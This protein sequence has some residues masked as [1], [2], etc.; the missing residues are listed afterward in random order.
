MMKGLWWM[1]GC[2]S[3]QHWVPRLRWV[4]FGHF[5]Y[6]LVGAN[7]CLG[8][9]QKDPQWFM[10]QGKPQPKKYR[11]H[12]T[13]YIVHSL[14]CLRNDWYMHAFIIVGNY[15]DDIKMHKK[16][17]IFQLSL[18][19]PSM[20]KDDGISAFHNCIQAKHCVISSTKLK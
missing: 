7:H 4:Y 19:A 10:C 13:S 9:N 12:T 1:Q 8:E 5:Q 11:Y 15:L 16:G 2:I 14:Q 6:S 3:F 18:H 20:I 17:E